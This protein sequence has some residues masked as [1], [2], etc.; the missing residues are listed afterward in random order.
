MRTEKKLWRNRNE[1]KEW[2]RRLQSEDPGLTVIHPQAA[3][4]DVGNSSHYV[5]VRPDRDAHPVRRFECFT[6]DLYRLADWLV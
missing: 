5:A 3:G 2:T 4:V 6:A 1:K